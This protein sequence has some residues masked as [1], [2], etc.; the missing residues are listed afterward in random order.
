MTMMN[1]D[2]S[3]KYV[4]NPYSLGELQAILAAVQ[5]SGLTLIDEY[6]KCYECD[7][8]YEGVAAF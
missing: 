6:L 8:K 7:K 2:G 3:T 4:Y 5:P 1:F